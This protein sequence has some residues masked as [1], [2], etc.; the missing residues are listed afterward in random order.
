M[1]V[2]CTALEHFK[3]RIWQYSDTASVRPCVACNMHAAATSHCEAATHS[4]QRKPS[5][6]LVIE[7]VHDNGVGCFTVPIQEPPVELRLHMFIG[8]HRLSS[9]MLG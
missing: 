4:S 3:L 7:G 8:S 5:P 2:S 9:H 1:A 6:S